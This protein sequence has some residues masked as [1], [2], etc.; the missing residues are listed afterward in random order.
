VVAAA[1]V[2]AALSWLL[3]C[4][5]GCICPTQPGHAAL[6]SA[7]DETVPVCGL[8]LSGSCKFVEPSAEVFCGPGV[9]T[10]DR[11]TEVKEEYTQVTRGAAG[12]GCCLQAGV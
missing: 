9:A 12:F 7:A 6:C 3:P 8:E 4:C 5:R 2:K 11:Y 1:G 10:C